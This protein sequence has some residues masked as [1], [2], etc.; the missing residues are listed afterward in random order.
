M[1]TLVL[2]TSVAF[3]QITLGGWGRGVFAAAVSGGN[4]P[5]SIALASWGPSGP[6]IGF[7]VKG[8]SPN[9][10]FI[11]T[12]TLDHGGVG[13]TNQ[14]MIWIKPI[15]MLTLKVG[16]I[17]DDTLRSAYLPGSYNW[18][19]FAGHVGAGGVFARV[20][21]TPLRPDATDEQANFEVTLAPIDGLYA[22]AGF[23]GKGSNSMSGLD[24]GMT[25][26]KLLETGSYGAGYTIPNIGVVRAQAVGVQ[27]ADYM[28]IQAAFKLTAVSGLT[29]D[30]GGFLPIGEATALTTLNL[31]AGID[32]LGTYTVGPFTAG[33]IAD[34][35]LM[36]TG[37][38]RYSVRVT[39]DYTIDATNGLGA[40]AE[41][42]YNNMDWEIAYGG[43]ANSAGTAT[44]GTICLLVGLTKGFSNG[45][46]G[47][48]F[49]GTTG[50]FNSWTAFAPKKTVDTFTWSVP[51]RLEYWF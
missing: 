3:A 4:D 29:V 21:E 26:I 8:N 30:V 31:T 34:L 47:I 49:E 35:R 51:I 45:V 10:G 46:V 20:G 25:S 17:L 18:M 1:L 33:L 5:Y 23:G 14:Q 6:R 40:T 22:Y 2:I 32:L 12:I 36:K 50:N 44:A 37:D 13:L 28:L 39:G 15:D 27:S 24:A 43:S 11:A 16:K 41:V 9:V 42:G 7:D 48:G 38:P 19:R